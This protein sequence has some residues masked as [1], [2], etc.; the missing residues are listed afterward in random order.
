MI[1]VILGT[2][3]KKFT[4]LLKEMDR[5]IASG[6]I[7]EEVIV[8]AGHSSNYQSSFMKI[9]DLINKDS[10]D[11]LI[12]KA[13]LV[14]THGGVGTI[15]TAL[16]YSKKII[17]VPRLKKYKEHVNDHQLQ[18]VDN[19]KE[20]GYIIGIHDVSELETAIHELK[21]FKPRKFKSNKKKM[22]ELVKELIDK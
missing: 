15:L 14:I 21:E 9:F 2:N 1:L 18:I 12:Q 3:D 6:T 17:A 22:L 19:F 8:Q 10:F 11:E 16:K 5:L 13:D 7:K 4:R 20:E